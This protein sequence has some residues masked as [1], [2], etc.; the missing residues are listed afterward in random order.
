MDDFARAQLALARHLRE[1]ARAV[2]AWDDR[3]IADAKARGDLSLSRTLFEHDLATTA[4]ML[5]GSHH[6]YQLELKGKRGKSSG[7][8]IDRKVD[9][10]IEIVRY[11][12]EVRRSEGRGGVRRGLDAAMDKYGISDGTAKRIWGK[13]RHAL[14]PGNAEIVPFFAKL[15]A[16]GLAKITRTKRGSKGK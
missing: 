12:D 3:D 10:E 9:R 2:K 7:A 11:I 1:I 14:V 8:A 5:E 4:A 15:E 16:K 6:L 13:L